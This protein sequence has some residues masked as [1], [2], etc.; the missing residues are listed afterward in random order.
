MPDKYID[1]IENFTTKL[2]L[3]IKNSKIISEFAGSS[4]DDLFGA[5]RKKQREI[6]REISAKVSEALRE[7]SDGP[8]AVDVA[9][10][11]TGVLMSNPASLESIS[12]DRLAK[13]LVDFA[14]QVNVS[15]ASESQLKAAVD[16]ALSQT[17]FLPRAVKRAFL[18]L[19]IGIA[20]SGAYDVL[21]YTLTRIYGSYGS[22]GKQD[23]EIKI[24]ESFGLGLRRLRVTGDN[25][26]LRS[27][28]SFD[29]KVV[30]LLP[31]GMQLWELA[32]HGDWVWV[33]IRHEGMDMEGVEIGWVHESFVRP[34][35]GI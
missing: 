23:V 4:P 13:P 29:D 33:S 1:R 16:R 18:A 27:G 32:N 35:D 24:D 21:R 31:K 8:D 19:M 9:P 6:S 34:V 14:L 26:R 11:V 2:T 5:G 25:L 28:P 17:A 3:S 12:D 10:S 20:G 22:E 15:G 30:R 7:I